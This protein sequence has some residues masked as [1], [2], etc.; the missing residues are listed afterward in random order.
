MKTFLHN[1]IEYIRTTEDLRKF[2]VMVL[3]SFVGAVIALAWNNIIQLILDIVREHSPSGSMATA[4]FVALI[5]T[6][7]VTFAGVSIIQFLQPRK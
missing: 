1:K 7:G 5:I 2:I 3:G 4:I 6:I